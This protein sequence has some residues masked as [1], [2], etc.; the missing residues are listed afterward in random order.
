[1]S[2][3][4]EKVLVEPTRLAIVAY[5]V[6]NG[7]KA[8]HTDLQRKLAIKHAGLL[9]THARRLES[10]GFIVAEKSFVGRMPCTTLQVTTQG[11]AA[12]SRLRATLDDITAPLEVAA[13]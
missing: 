1:M 11:R 3:F 5:L 12:L 2:T 6:A 9:A 7:G 13:A 8:R 4:P 10:V